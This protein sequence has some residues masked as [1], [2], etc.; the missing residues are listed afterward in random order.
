VEL[1]AGW[2]WLSHTGY[3]PG[4][5]ASNAIVRNPRDGTWI[6]VS[7]LTNADDVRGLEALSAEIVRAAKR[8]VPVALLPV[9]QAPVFACPMAAQAMASPMQLPPHLASR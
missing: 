7:L 9:K 8:H 4:F 6:S 5:T 3:V 1:N 2:D